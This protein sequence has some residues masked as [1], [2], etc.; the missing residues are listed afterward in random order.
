M[1]YWFTKALII[2]CKERYE[3]AKYI[4]IRAFH[5]K[6]K[7]TLLLLFQIIAITNIIH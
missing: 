2:V 6:N 3:M 7:A 4:K 1:I 5:E